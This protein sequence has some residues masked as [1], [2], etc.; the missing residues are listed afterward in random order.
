MFKNVFH[1][2]SG[3]WL[4]FR[5]IIWVMNTYLASFQAG[6]FIL[7]NLHENWCH[8]ANIVGCKRVLFG[9]GATGQL[10]DTSGGK[11]RVMPPPKKNNSHLISKRSYSRRKLRF[12]QNKK[13]Y[14]KLSSMRKH[15]I[16]VI[17]WDWEE[18]LKF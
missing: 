11:G 5:L 15:P 3:K 10:S 9:G 8:S 17:F 14:F 18:V 12:F 13:V 16:L 1:K 2:V 6:I 7:I 4:A